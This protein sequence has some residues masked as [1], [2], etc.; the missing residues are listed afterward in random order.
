MFDDNISGETSRRSN[1]DSQI[2]GVI[3]SAAEWLAKRQKPEGYWVGQ[4]ESNSCMEAQWI[5]CL[6]VIGQENHHLRQRLAQSLLDQQREDGSWEVFHNAPA[7]DINTTVEAYAALRSM[8]MDPGQPALA[9]ARDWIIAKGGLKNIRVFTR[10]W[11]ALIGEWPWEKT[12]TC[13]RK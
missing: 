2:S 12:P 10:Y 1:Y 3:D 5:L 6:W 13:R 9:K 8:G 7:G 4:L 11:L